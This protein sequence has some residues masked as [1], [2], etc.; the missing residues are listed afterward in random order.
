MMEA[1]RD[2][3]FAICT[4]HVALSTKYDACVLSHF[5]NSDKLHFESEIG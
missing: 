4:S 1:L 5:V 3:T 2:M